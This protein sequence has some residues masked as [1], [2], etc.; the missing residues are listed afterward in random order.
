[1]MAVGGTKIVSEFLYHKNFYR[2]TYALR[3]GLCCSMKLLTK[4]GQLG[5]REDLSVRMLFICPYVTYNKCPMK[6]V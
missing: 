1:M 3:V 4:I 2:P 6:M 5:L